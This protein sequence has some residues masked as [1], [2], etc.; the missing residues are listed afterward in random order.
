MGLG[1]TDSGLGTHTHTHTHTYMYTR[2]TQLSLKS[3]PPL[4][5]HSL[6]AEDSLELSATFSGNCL[7][8]LGSGRGRGTQAGKEA[9]PPNILLH[10]PLPNSK[11]EGV[12]LLPSFWKGR[13]HLPE[14]D[15]DTRGYN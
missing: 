9:N 1:L 11:Q 4:S 13:H 3:Y 12:L 6:G 5:M 2:A 10:R 8:R 15:R 7:P 14:G